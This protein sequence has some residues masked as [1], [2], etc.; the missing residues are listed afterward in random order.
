MGNTAK[1]LFSEVLEECNPQR[2]YAR[3]DRKTHQETVTLQW[4][5]SLAPR[6]GSMPCG[7][8]DMPK[9]WLKDS[10]LNK[11]RNMT[12]EFQSLGLA[13]GQ[14]YPATIGHF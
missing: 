13:C 11:S 2:L 4:S 8:Q 3:M 5:F 9:L 7:E 6:L 10:L 1:Y 14:F 12:P